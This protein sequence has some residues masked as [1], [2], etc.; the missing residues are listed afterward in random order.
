MGLRYFAIFVAS[1]V[2]LIRPPAS[3][4][5]LM[6]PAVY[7]IHE[8]YRITNPGP[9]D[10][11]VTVYLLKDWS[12]WATQLVLAE[13]LP[14]GLMSYTLD[15]RTTHFS[16]P[17]GTHTTAFAQTVKVYGCD[18]Q[19]EPSAIGDSVHAGFGYTSFVD[20]LW[21]NEPELVEKARELTDAQP[22]FYHKAK[23][24]FEF[25]RDNIRYE[26][27][28]PIYSA[29]ET[30]RYGRG[31]CADKA[32]LFIGL[33][34]SVG[35][36]AKFVSCYGYKAEHDESIQDPSLLGH[37]FAIVYLPG[38]GWAPVD[39]TW[40]G[41]KGL[42]GKLGPDHIISATSDGSDMFSLKD[43]GRLVSPDVARIWGVPGCSIERES[44]LAVREIAL[45]VETGPASAEI[46]D[47]KWRWFVKIK[48][49]GARNVENLKVEIQVEEPHLEPPSP[50]KIDKLGAGFD[51]TVYFDIGIKGSVENATIKAIV[52]YDWAFGDL[53][54]K[55]EAK[56]E[57][58]NMSVSILSPT[59]PP[60]MMDP[61]PMVLLAAAGTVAAILI[62]LVKRR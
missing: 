34:R 33:C 45:K 15:N 2:L 7:T 53:N 61:M 44:F 62:V 26:P 36:P 29:Y 43:P 57:R 10:A 6:N 27:T 30:Y 20:G 23:A 8:N 31:D 52:T 38:A 4:V 39:P 46:K 22:N 51:Q 60:G 9:S 11:T 19:L 59:L 54:G 5:E 58:P 40:D 41:P 55:F 48:N 21:E 47:D 42:F 35:I 25:V 13:T 49:I 3:A 28:D 24:I 12:D 32:N 1:F 50:E 14:S 16:I 18:V 17:P 37:A 56:T